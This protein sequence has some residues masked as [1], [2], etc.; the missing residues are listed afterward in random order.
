VVVSLFDTDAGRAEP[1][2]LRVEPLVEETLELSAVEDEQ[3]RPEARLEPFGRR[4]GEKRSS[5]G[6]EAGIL[7]RSS[8]RLDGLAETEEPQR[9]DGVRPE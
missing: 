8:G 7:R 6:E 5:R 1:Y 2:P 3:R 9:L 4:G